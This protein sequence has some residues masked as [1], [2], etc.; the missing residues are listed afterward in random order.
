MF[1][2]EFP[3]DSYKFIV[4][5][6]SSMLYL[7]SSIFEFVFFFPET[8]F[9]TKIGLMLLDWYLRCELSVLLDE[10]SELFMLPEEATLDE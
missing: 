4:L 1:L 5:Q 7:P 10:E 2:E 9:C 8:L 3:T 6:T